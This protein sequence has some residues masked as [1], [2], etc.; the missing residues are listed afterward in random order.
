[1][2]RLPTVDPP[3]PRWWGQLLLVVGFAWAYDEVRSLH[4]DVVAAG[5]R[6]GHAVLHA[7]RVLH[8]DWSGRLNAWLG[9]HDSLADILAGYYVVM[10]L[11][12]VALTL[13]LLWLQ[14]RHYRHH[15]DALIVASLVGFGVY[16]CYPVAPPRLLG[17]DAAHDTVAQVFPLAYT[18]ETKSANLYAAIPSLHVAWAVW[19]AVAVWAMTSR[20]WLRALAAAHPVIT[21]VTVLATGN[22]YSLDVASGVAL[23]VVSYPLL[24]AGQTLTRSVGGRVDRAQQVRRQHGKEQQERQDVDTGAP[25]AERL[26]LHRLDVHQ[27]EDHA[28]AGHRSGEP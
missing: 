21:A 6:H 14:G 1:V 20:W 2:R 11:G 9:H 23:I 10:H 5:L 22:H 17:G 19:V 27:V 13:L 7:D 25:Q 18:V 28:D 15:R 26:E 3:R 16:W 24:A 12:M 4:G 8:I